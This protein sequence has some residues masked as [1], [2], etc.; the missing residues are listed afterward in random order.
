MWTEKHLR[1]SCISVSCGTIAY[2]KL[3]LYRM[4]FL[5]WWGW[6]R[7]SEVA[8]TLSPPDHSPLSCHRDTRP[9]FPRA[10]GRGGELRSLL[11]VDEIFGTP[12]LGR[13]PVRNVSLDSHKD[14]NVSQLTPPQFTVSK[15]GI[16]NS[17]W[18]HSDF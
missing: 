16:Q 2:R 3:L 6:W 7:I 18:G 12:G 9:S 10:S 13:N 4:N 17:C 1:I 14:S 8:A 11:L 5:G 15:P